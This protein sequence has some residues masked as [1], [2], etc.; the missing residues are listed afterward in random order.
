MLYIFS[1]VWT[2]TYKNHL[3]NYHPPIAQFWFCKLR[4]KRD[5]SVSKRLGCG[6]FCLRYFRQVLTQAL[7]FQPSSRNC[8]STNLSK[9]ADCICTT[10]LYMS[11]SSTL[12]MEKNINIFCLFG[13]VLKLLAVQMLG[14]S[15]LE[16]RFLEIA[17]YW[18]TGGPS[19]QSC[20]Q[21]KILQ[22][23]QE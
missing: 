16:F 20:C 21:V 19:A 5:K 7:L 15:N 14:L 4:I 22:H 18:R 11:L 9:C 12:Q 10:P 6:Q 1:Q 13:K 8:F 23:F 2:T 17:I 3:K